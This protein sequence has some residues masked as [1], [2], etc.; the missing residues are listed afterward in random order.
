MR[1]TSG[2]KSYPFKRGILL[3]EGQEFSSAARY[4]VGRG[5]RQ[6]KNPP[7]ISQE[8]RDDRAQPWNS[9]GGRVWKKYLP[10]RKGGTSTGDL[11]VKGGTTSIKEKET[12]AFPSTGG[13]P[14]GQRQC[15]QSLSTKK[16]I[17]GRIEGRP[18][19][20]LY[21]QRRDAACQLCP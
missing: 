7:F 12:K 13:K 8:P 15:Y 3:P 5:R 18:T 1:K 17:V 10:S 4:D 16:E 9:Q 11:S 14:V 19:V 2:G 20:L 21:R 6:R